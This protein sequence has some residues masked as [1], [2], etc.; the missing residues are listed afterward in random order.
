[1]DSVW[2][3][4]CG[5][6]IEAGGRREERC[7]ESGDSGR[8]RIG[9]RMTCKGELKVAVTALGCCCI[10]TR[11][12]RLV[13]RRLR[14]I[15]PSRMGRGGSTRGCGARTVRFHRVKELRRLGLAR[16]ERRRMSLLWLS[17]T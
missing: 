11:S 12:N 7:Y 3:G 2:F 14:V 15:V 5:V 17:W 16:E 10:R 8:V 9:K 6:F 13:R 1:M 4:V